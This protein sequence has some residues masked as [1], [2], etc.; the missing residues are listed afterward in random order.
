MS[1]SD[2]LSP[3]HDIVQRYKMEKYVPILSENHVWKTNWK[4][5]TENFME[6][7]H[8]PITHQATVATWFSAEK[9]VFQQILTIAS[10]I[11]PS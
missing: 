5:L 1:V 3:L 9:T 10:H 4:S 8:L 6:G 11:K 7:Y 2:A